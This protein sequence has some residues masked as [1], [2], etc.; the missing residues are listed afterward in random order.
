MR[1][2]GVLRTVCLDYQFLLLTD[3]IADIWSQWLL[4]P[5]LEPTKPTVTQ[6][7]PE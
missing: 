6:I 3:K 2:F 1:A 7:P 5:K 4:V